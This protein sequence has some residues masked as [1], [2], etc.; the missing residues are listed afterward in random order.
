[1]RANGI[2]SNSG[3]SSNAIAAYWQITTFM[4][5]IYSSETT[6][7]EALLSSYIS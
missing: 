7:I 1:M 3:T 5:C 4:Y 2:P 6:R